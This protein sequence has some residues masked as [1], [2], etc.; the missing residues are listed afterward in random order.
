MQLAFPPEIEAFVQRQLN[1]DKYQS[2]EDLI[3]AAV[4]LLQQQE[5]IYQGRLGELQQDA[6]I[7]WEASQQGQTI[8]GPTA[9]S[10]V[11]ANLRDRR[12]SSNT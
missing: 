2:V 3:L 12:E 5:D 10:Q 4:E 6:M 9:M 8:D 7:G 11:R 1:S